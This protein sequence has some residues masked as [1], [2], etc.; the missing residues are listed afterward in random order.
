M[1][2]VFIIENVFDF[3]VRVYFLLFTPVPFDT[4]TRRNVVCEIPIQ[5]Q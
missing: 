1:S 4:V 5:Y 3:V 2:F